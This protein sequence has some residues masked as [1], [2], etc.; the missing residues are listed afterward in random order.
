LNFRF[1]AGISYIQKPFNRLSNYKNNAIGSHWNSAVN[2]LLESKYKFNNRTHF[3]VGFAINHFSNGAIKLP[4]LGINLASVNLSLLY[5]IGKVP[6]ISKDSTIKSDKKY[7]FFFTAA[8]GIKEI[9]P[10]GGSKFAI[11]NG[12]LNVAKVNSNKAKYGLAIDFMHDA[13]IKEQCRRDQN[14][15]SSAEILQIGSALFY[16]LTMG[17]VSFPLQIGAYVHSTYPTVA[18]IYTRFGFRYHFNRNLFSSISLKTHYA[19]ADY[20]EWGI[21][22]SFQTKKQFYD[23]CVHC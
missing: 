8:S 13:S 14:P 17:D 18:P 21:G 19:K 12:S 15:C 10:A 6:L 23:K 4:N 22:Y 5:S 3:G 20:F 16:E 11:I 9:A 7:E 2:L 1:G